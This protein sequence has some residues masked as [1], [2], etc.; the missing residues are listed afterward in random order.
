[1]PVI[2]S[3]FLCFDL[4][5]FVKYFASLKE[6]GASDEGDAGNSNGTSPITIETGDLVHY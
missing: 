1:M 2:F 4:F 5:S 6:A 3:S